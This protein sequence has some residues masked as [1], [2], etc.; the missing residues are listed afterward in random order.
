MDQHYYERG[1][2]GWVYKSEYRTKTHPNEY[3]IDMLY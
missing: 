2:M 3:A 1:G